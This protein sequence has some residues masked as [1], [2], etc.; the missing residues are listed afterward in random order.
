[1]SQHY[2]HNIIAAYMTVYFTQCYSCESVV[3]QLIV[4]FVQIIHTLDEG[5]ATPA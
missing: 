1:M 5:I 2:C 3:S 4:L